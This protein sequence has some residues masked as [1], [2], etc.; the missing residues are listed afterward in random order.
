MIKIVYAGLLGVA[1]DIKSLIQGIDFK[2][3]DAELHL[4]G[5]GNQK[6]DIKGYIARCPDRGVFFHGY[7]EPTELREVLKQYDAALIPLAT[8]IKGAVPSKIFDTLPLGLPILFCGDGEG[9]EIVRKYQVGFVSPPNDEK[10]LRDNILRLSQM[11]EQDRKMIGEREKKVAREEF[12]FE[13]QMD[14]CH[15]FIKGLVYAEYE[16]NIISKQ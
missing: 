9:A 3:L 13:K 15:Q 11:T 1:Q 8:Y 4:Y 14:K 5:G 6:E 7:V 10:G 2:K 12:D 16:K